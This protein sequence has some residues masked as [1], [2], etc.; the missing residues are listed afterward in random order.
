[1][2]FGFVTPADLAQVSN[3]LSAVGN[4]ATVAGNVGQ[5]LSS[6]Q[7]LYRVNNWTRIAHI[8]RRASRTA[9]I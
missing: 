5:A 8:R 6:L 7:G 3:V 1:M 2:D 4:T 9:P